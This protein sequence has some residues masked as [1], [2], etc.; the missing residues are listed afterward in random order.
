DEYYGAALLARRLEAFR[1]VLYTG[2]MSLTNRDAAVR[3]FQEDSSRQVMVLSLR[4]GGQGLNLQ[5]ASYVFHFDRWWNPAV[6][7][8]ATD[9]S[10]RLGQ[11]K[12]VHVYSYTIQNSI[13]ERIQDILVNKRELFERIVEGVGIDVHG[14]SR[15]ELFHMVGLARP[16]PP[17]AARAPIDF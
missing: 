2:A 7:D 12:P 4:A 10:H 6:E 11:R 1:P 16:V 9:R 17:P 13:E 15:D 3:R 5:G 14:F 8:Q